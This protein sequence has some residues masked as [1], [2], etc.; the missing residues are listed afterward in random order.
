MVIYRKIGGVILLTQNLRAKNGHLMGKIRE[1]N[2]KYDLKDRNGRHLGY[3]D[4]K[5]N[6]T[7]DRSGKLVGRGNLLASLLNI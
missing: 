2:G 5:T 6:K 4:P 1:V 3:Y 7:R